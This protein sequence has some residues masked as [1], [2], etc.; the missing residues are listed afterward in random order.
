MYNTTLMKSV[1][2]TINGNVRGRGRPELTWD[3]VGKKI[4]S[5]NLTE[6]ITLDREKQRKTIHVADPTWFGHKLA[7]VWIF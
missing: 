3:A 6:D 5:F 7:L 1:I 4:N 2:I